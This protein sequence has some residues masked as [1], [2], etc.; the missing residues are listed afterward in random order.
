[1]KEEFEVYLHGEQLKDDKIIKVSNNQSVRDLLKSFLDFSKLG[2]DVNEIKLYL[3]DKEDFKDQNLNVME[4]GIKRHS[5]IH[6]HRCRHISLTV[7]YNG[8][9]K[10]RK[11]APSATG[12][13]ILKWAIKEFEISES[14]AANLVLRINSPLGEIL[15]SYGHIGSF[16]HFPH[17]KITLFLTPNIQVQG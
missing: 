12:K 2:S 1:M 16:V 13:R 17:C 10:D 6:C 7:T 3:E 14:D 15:Q 5:H 11:F 8:Q 4:I 9:N